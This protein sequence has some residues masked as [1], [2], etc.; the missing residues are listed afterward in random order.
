MV[1]KV[2]NGWNGLEWFDGLD[3]FLKNFEMDFL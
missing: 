3:G 1:G 2:W